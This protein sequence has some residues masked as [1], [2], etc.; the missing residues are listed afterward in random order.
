MK[1]LPQGPINKNKGKDA[2]TIW[3]G[4]SIKNVST[5]MLLA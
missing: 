4:A 1:S 2:L 5:M 3:V